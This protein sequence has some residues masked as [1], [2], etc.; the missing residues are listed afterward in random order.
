M[1]CTLHYDESDLCRLP[2]RVGDKA[3]YKGVETTID[4]I[5]IRSFS[6]SINDIIVT[7]EN[8]EYTFHDD[9]ENFNLAV[10]W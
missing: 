1:S 4:S 5:Y 6:C 3:I 10:D 9:Q 2:F 8:G 7:F